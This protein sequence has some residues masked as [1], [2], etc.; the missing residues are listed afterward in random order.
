MTKINEVPR[1]FGVFAEL[2]GNRNGDDLSYKTF[3][4]DFEENLKLSEKY[5]D[6]DERTYYRLIIAYEDNKVIKERVQSVNKTETY[7]FV[8]PY[9]EVAALL[10]LSE[11]E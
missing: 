5:G 7:G 8:K 3:D 4:L 2:F 1:V 9:E 10:D 11:V 6:G